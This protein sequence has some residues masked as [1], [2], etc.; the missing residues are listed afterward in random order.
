[1]PKMPSEQVKRHARTGEELCQ[2]IA[3][4]DADLSELGLMS[5]IGE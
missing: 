2:V 3:A 5:L 4:P 1:M